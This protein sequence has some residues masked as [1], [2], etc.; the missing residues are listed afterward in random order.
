LSADRQRFDRLIGK[1]LEHEGGY[2]CD[3]ADPGGETKYGICKRSYPAID[4]KSLTLE[5]AK[6][7][8]Y[9]E[10]WLRLRCN[11]IDN[12]QVAQKLLD[13]AVNVGASTGV[14]LLQSALCDVG[15]WVVVDGVIGPKTVDAV[16]R[17][18]PNRL[19]TAMRARQAEHYREL[20]KRNPTLARFQRGWE[21]RAY[22]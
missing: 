1:V 11:D 3:P 21:K 10:W 6:G 2:V 12:D 5:Q 22:A 9:C 17:A 18:D 4:I 8:Y 7:I 13:T 16:N 14:K 15:Q 20:I 19:L